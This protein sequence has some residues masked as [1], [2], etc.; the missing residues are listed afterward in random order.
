MKPWIKWVSYFLIFSFLIT[1]F[2]ACVKDSSLGNTTY[3]FPFVYADSRHSDF[4]NFF[5]PIKI[6]NFYERNLVLNLVFWLVVFGIFY[7]IR[8]KEILKKYSG[9]IKYGL[10][11]V[12]ILILVF[13]IADIYDNEPIGYLG[14]PGLYTMLFTGGLLQDWIEKTPAISHFVYDTLKS[15]YPFE[16]DLPSR[17]G[18]IFAALIY[19]IF[20]IVVYRIKSWYIKRKNPK[21]LQ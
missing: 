4:P 20:G 17:F 13:L 18:F 1:G 16:D 15:V 14:L 19:F 7:S 8:N 11:M 5:K 10:A 3:G 6:M 12:V 21:K 9:E 2:R